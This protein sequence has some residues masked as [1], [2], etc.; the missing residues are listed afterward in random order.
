MED[1]VR[2]LLARHGLPTTARN[3]AAEAVLDAMTRDKKARRGR[4]RFSL[5]AAVGDPV[6]GAELPDRLVRQAVDRALAE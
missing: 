1:E 6:W 2:E 3:V 4:V 5:L